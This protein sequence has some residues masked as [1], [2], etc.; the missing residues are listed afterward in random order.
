VRERRIPKASK[1][2]DVDHQIKE[3]KRRKLQYYFKGRLEGSITSL[4]KQQK[5]WNLVIL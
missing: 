1:S 5:S 2:E 4:E 3:A